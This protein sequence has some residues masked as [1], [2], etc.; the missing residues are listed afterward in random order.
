MISLNFRGSRMISIVS[1]TA[2]SA[3][4]TDGSGKSSNVIRLSKWRNHAE[5]LHRGRFD[6]HLHQ[7]CLFAAFASEYVDIF[8]YLEKGIL[9]RPFQ[10]VLRR[11]A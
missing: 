9:K 5:R 10:P 1:S 7:P 11:A 3:G 2:L 8:V 4:C 6:L